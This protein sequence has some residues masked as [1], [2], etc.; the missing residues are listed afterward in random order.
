MYKTIDVVAMHAMYTS[1]YYNYMQKKLLFKSQRVNTCIE[2]N[3]LKKKKEK[4]A[5]KQL[6]PLFNASKSVIL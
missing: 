4:E 2:Q 5:K 1:L 6:L 3:P